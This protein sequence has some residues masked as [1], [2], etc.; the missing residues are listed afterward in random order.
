V[1]SSA[2]LVVVVIVLILGV[3]GAYYAFFGPTVETPSRSPEPTAPPVQPDRSGASR[4]DRKGSLER[5]PSE[6]SSAFDTRPKTSAPVIDR[7]TPPHPVEPGAEQDEA[8][9]TVP[10]VDRSPRPLPGGGKDDVPS[11]LDEPAATNPEEGPPGS[12]T[13]PSSEQPPATTQPQAG[14]E[15]AT[16]PTTAP[17]RP[18]SPSPTTP[19]GT[20]TPVAPERPTPQPTNPPRP[21][22]GPTA[23]AYQDY[24]VQS[25][26]TMTSIA[27]E[28]F[29]DGGKWDLI[30]K[31]NP[32][33]D[34]QRLKVGQV[35]RLPPKSTQREPVAPQTPA[36]AAVTYA[37]R[38]GDTLSKI[39]E[40][41]YGDKSKWRTIY[42]AN[43]ALIGDDP[44]TLQ[45]GMK[46]T[47]PPAPT[48][49][50]R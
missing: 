48:G 47:I 20:P 29:G 17:D 18:A 9:P 32:L 19:P 10:P 2:K 6:R 45:V 11:E 27:E 14:D 41:Y 33:V 7:G 16:Q 4:E 40:A 44:A 24:T 43:R 37:V 34:P 30:S 31:A 21:A 26:D 35:L 15:P 3:A 38:S 28:W 39:A 5:E 13:S 12:S 8:A 49:A 46:L 22:A 42:D 1:T 50:R 23:P 25:G 36:G